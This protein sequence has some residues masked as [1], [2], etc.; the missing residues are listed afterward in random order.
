MPKK[1]I[2]F[3]HAITVR[4]DDETYAALRKISKS[5]HRPPATVARL[6]I[7]MVCSLGHLRLHEIEDVLTPKTGG[8]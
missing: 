3:P 8:R 7:Q 6:V 2:E 5:D 4:L 1:S